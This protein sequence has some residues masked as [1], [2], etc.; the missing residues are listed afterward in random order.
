MLQAKYFVL[1]VHRFIALMQSTE[2]VEI[3]INL[4]EMEKSLPFFTGSVY[5]TTVKQIQ[6]MFGFF[7]HMVNIEPMVLRSNRLYVTQKFHNTCKSH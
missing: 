2:C 6:C 7:V 3:D 1:V 4:E 5:L